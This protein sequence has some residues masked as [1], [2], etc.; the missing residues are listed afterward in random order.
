MWLQ[1][2]HQQHTRKGTKLPPTEV[3][4]QL[5]AYLNDTNRPSQYLSYKISVQQNGYDCAIYTLACLDEIMHRWNNLTTTSAV[6]QNADVNILPQVGNFSQTDITEFR[7][8]IQKLILGYDA[9]FDYVANI[10]LLNA[11]ATCFSTPHRLIEHENAKL[12]SESL[13][14]PALQTCLTFFSDERQNGHDQQSMLDKRGN[15]GMSADAAERTDKLTGIETNINYDVG[16]ETKLHRDIMTST[17]SATLCYKPQD[18]VYWQLQ[19]E[20]RYQSIDPDHH[21]LGQ[22]KIRLS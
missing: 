15:D 6:H 11:C 4:N 18:Q 12:V 1:N 7:T 16:V 9:D 5:N 20:A 2:Y 14:S 10:S 22:T 21:L 19:K 3:H 17:I 13:S 8:N